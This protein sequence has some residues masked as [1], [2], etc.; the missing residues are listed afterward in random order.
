MSCLAV[1]IDVGAQRSLFNYELALKQGQSLV[2]RTDFGGCPEQVRKKVEMGLR[3]CHPFVTVA[4]WDL[5]AGQ[6]TAG[7]QEDGS[8]SLMIKQEAPICSE[9]MH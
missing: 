2:E 9:L 6:E 8:Y 3:R 7:A 1:Y 4:F 5:H